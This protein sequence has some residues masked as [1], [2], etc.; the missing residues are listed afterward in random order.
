MKK[1]RHWAG[2]LVLALCFSLLGSCLSFAAAM[3]EQAEQDEVLNAA[4]E[5]VNMI[6]AMNEAELEDLKERALEYDE[7]ALASGIDNWRTSLEDLGPVTEI[8]SSSFRLGEDGLYY[9][10]LM[11]N[12]M[13]RDTEVVV[14]MDPKTGSITQF[15]VNPVYTL[16]E[17]MGKAFLNLVAGMGT[18][19][20]VLILL[21]FVI[22]GFKYVNQFEAKMRAKAEAK[23]APA[24]P[25]APAP[26][27]AAAPVL[28]DLS[29]DTALAAVIAAAIAAYEG[30]SPEGLVVRSIRRAG[31][32]NQ[33]RRS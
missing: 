13:K 1:L 25:A 8:A 12:C 21:M 33:W 31:K 29:S 3:P 28:E 16:S 2:A 20:I 24:A 26:A 6:G 30:S 17:K 23:K 11:V 5:I 22:Y 27:P 32:T 18:V 14:G 9:A 15:S 7:S 19:F 4:Q 10:D